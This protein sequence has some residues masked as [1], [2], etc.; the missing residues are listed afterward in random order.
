MRTPSF[1][2]PPRLVLGGSMVSVAVIGGLVVGGLAATTATLVVTDPLAPA[3]SADSL[4]RFGSCSDLLD[5]YV[6]HSVDEVG[7]YGWG[8]PA[9][10]GGMPID[11]GVV[12]QDGIAADKSVAGAAPEAAAGS[13]DTRA[14]SATGTNTQ[15]AD[16]DEPDVAKTDGR[17]VVR[18]VDQRTVV[19]DDVTG[20]EPVELGRVSLPVDAYGG[21]LLLAGDHVVVTQSN[22]AWRGPMPYEGDVAPG[23][24]DGKTMAP[25]NGTRVLD[26]DISDPALPRIVHDDTYSGTEVS[27]RLYGDTIRLVTSTERPQLPWVMPDRP[28]AGRLS[29]AEATRRNRAL[30]R[31][32]T[33]EDWLPSVVDNTAS[34][35]RKTLVGCSDVYHPEQW[36]GAGTTTVT[37]Y[38]VKDPAA[39][40]SVAVTADGQVVYS[41]ADRLYVTS[42]RVDPPSTWRRMYGAV[43]GGG[44]IPSRPRDVRTEVHAFA[45]DGTSTRYVGS[46]HVDGTVR[47]RWSLDEHGGL[48]RVA[49]TRDGSRVIRDSNGEVRDATR[50]GITILSERDGALVPTGTIGDLGINE[51]IQSVRWFD[52][53]AV[54]VTFRQMDPLYTI[55]LT[56]PAHPREIGQLKI[57]GYSGYLHPIGD[58]LLLGL[59]VDATDLGRNLGAQ[60][61]VFDIT[62]L[63]A[64]RRVSQQEFGL[65]TSLAALDDPRGFTWLPDRR[66]GLTSV[67]S[68]MT[69]HSRLVALK[70]STDGALEARDLA[71]DIGYD[72]RTLPLADGRVAV[73]DDQGVRLL[74]VA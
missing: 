44:M 24:L 47:D 26:I 17:R 2:T 8:G 57:P 68:W 63:A 72:A 5:W 12:L 31:A 11:G 58:H 9:V 38:D 1:V 53:V 30:V 23:L 70:V 21:E 27:A 25:A 69:D 60:A 71:T 4:S 62:D 48:L 16:V 64:P 14:S 51:N 15:E 19:V 18:L 22:A 52:D 28:G 49:W 32:T 34:A 6:G 41:S 65:E 29:A 56:D 20:A 37:T 66:T 74:D 54:L 45:L 7:P 59:G 73:V 43:T 40:S 33:I 35:T 10:Y 13:T 67:Q 50:N 55:D 3:A 46:G 36:S 61:A 39:R 42:T